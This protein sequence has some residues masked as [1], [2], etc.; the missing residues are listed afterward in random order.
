MVCEIDNSECKAGILSV[1]ASL[2]HVVKF[3]D[4]NGRS[5][6][7]KKNLIS[8]EFG[9]LGAGEVKKIIILFI[10]KFLLLL[11]KRLL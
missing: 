10:F 7:H 6:Y 5:T 9:G 4:N 3:K 2:L 11:L 1:N 8:K